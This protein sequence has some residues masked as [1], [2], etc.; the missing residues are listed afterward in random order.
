MRTITNQDMRCSINMESLYLTQHDRLK[1]FIAKKVWN[2]EDVE[3]ILQMTFLEAVRCQDRYA[4]DSK[5]E[6]WLFGIAVNLMR[7][8]FKRHYGQV[9]LDEITDEILTTLE[10]DTEMDP[11]ML[12]EHESILDKT[13]EAMEEMPE[14]VQSIFRLIIDGDNS[15]QDAAEYIG[16][17]VGTI[18]SRLSRAR[19]SLKN[20]LGM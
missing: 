7:N 19:K 6:T 8:Y 1:R 20:C 3:D 13:M 12:L 5:P 16:V 15:Y 18:R 9:Q 10:A 11:S 4:G 17:P 2:E 14:D